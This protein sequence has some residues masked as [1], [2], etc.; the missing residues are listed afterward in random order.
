MIPKW[1]A[2]LIFDAG[3]EHVGGDMFQNVPKGDAIMIK[4]EFGYNRE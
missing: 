2:Q 3:V 4:V 1:R